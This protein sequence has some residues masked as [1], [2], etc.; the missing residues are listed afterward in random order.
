MNDH[1][2][3][4][5][6]VLP[7][8]VWRTYSGGLQLDL[9]ERRNI[10]AD[11]PFPEDWIGSTVK[12]INPD[13]DQPDEGLAR[14]SFDGRSAL[15]AELISADAEYFLGSE[16]LDRFGANPMLLVKYLDSAV[17]L[18]FQVHPTVQFSQARLNASSGKTEA[19][20][21][22]KIRPEVPKPFIYLG[23][24]RPPSRDELRRMINEQDIAAMERC[25]DKIP[26]K[27]GDVFVVPGGLPHAIGGGVLMVEIMEP[28]DFV[29]RVEFN[30]A[31]RVIPE[32]ARF[33]DRDADF[34]L[35]MFSYEPLPVE[36]VLSRWRCTP[37][38][39]ESSN[40]LRR[41]SYVDDRV[42]DRF[43]V[44]RT[45]INGHTRWPAKGFTILLLI[46]GKCIIS[47]KRE[48]V[49]LIKFDRILIPDGMDELEIIAEQPAVF[50]EC[51]P[52][53]A[54]PC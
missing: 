52:P 51:R 13:R 21:I 44:L 19:Y 10:P 6:R 7:N 46:E 49:A 38:I 31:G 53:S 11:G 41:E 45:V 32:P 39:I 47:T 33:M 40:T 28:T 54:N 5:L 50:L 15:L 22:L 2:G 8:R 20:Y 34:A 23:F 27:P 26:V 36:K 42:T 35:D 14:V 24:Q 25:F 16:H 17:R 48:K 30:V 3:K 43:Q 9:I 29:A 1:R 12:A 37:R 4:I 18:P